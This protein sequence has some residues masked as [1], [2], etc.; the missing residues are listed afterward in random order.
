[1]KYWPCICRICRPSVWLAALLLLPA[2]VL[3]APGDELY[4]ENFNSATLPW[5]T[6]NAT[7]SGTQGGN[8]VRQSGPRGGYT[9][10][11]AVT[12][13][14][15]A[16]INAA[17]PA[18]RLEIWVRRGDDDIPGNNPNNNQSEDPDNNENFVIEYQRANSTWGQIVTYLGSGTKGQIYN[19]SFVLP[20]DALHNAL[21][22][23]VRQTDGSG[24]DYDYWHFDDVVVTEIA[25]PPPLGVGSCDYFEL[26][27]SNWTVNQTTGFAGI[28]SAT[29]S[30]PVNSMYLNGGVV[31]VTSS[32]VDS[33]DVTFSDI[34]MWIRSGSDA[35]SED[36]DN[37]EDL[38]VE[39][40]NDVGTWILLETF[41][42]QDA[43]G[44]G[45]IY[46]R[47]YTLPADGHH[48]NLRVRFRQTDGDGPTWDFWH[49]DDVCFT[50][51][52]DP[53]LVTSKNSQTISD[54]VNLGAFPKSI[55][56]SVT[57]YTIEVTNHGLGPVDIDSMVITDPV[58]DN[59]DLYVD[60]SG[61][62]PIVFTDGTVVSGLT[63]AYANDVTFSNQVGG[64]APYNYAPVPDAQGFDPAV[65]GY[66]INP[67]QS[68]NGASGLNTPSFT[69]DFRVRI[70]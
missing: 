37:G 12:V 10:H 22:I 44:A 9:R 64:G 54:P 47:S 18:A 19:A 56:G 1:M 57:Q 3:A 42:G 28:S 32:A 61:G 46:N 62:D 55:P 34:A 67:K 59:T 25:V 23:R 38:V 45:V 29:S 66:R 8:Q 60:T 20:A 26:G 33:T 21:A 48:A 31:D 63:Y 7:A 51:S 70:E 24:S 69:I 13:T 16:T 65:T 52:T 35:F 53:V 5:A 49:V 36:P 43:G 2:T 4:R 15:P 68:M 6:T 14:G 39:Y 11:T 27:L 50:Q 58:P 17:V 40:L 30:S 41:A